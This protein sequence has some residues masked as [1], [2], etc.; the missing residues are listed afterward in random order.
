MRVNPNTNAVLSYLLSHLQL[1]Q[2][3]VTPSQ[4]YQLCWTLC[5][6]ADL[7][8]HDVTASRS[9]NKT[10]T[11]WL[12]ILVQWTDVPWILVVVNHLQ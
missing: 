11:N 4:I 8:F 12:V 9:S 2:C 5:D 3:V 7:Q 6:D 1:V 10:R